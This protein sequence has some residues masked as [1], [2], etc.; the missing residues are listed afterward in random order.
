MRNSPKK[1]TEEEILFLKDNYYKTS[2]GYCA[3]KLK[4][5]I[6]VVY[7]K[8]GRLKLT[9]ECKYNIDIFRSIESK[10]VSYLFG[11]IW[12]DGHVRHDSIIL[13]IL[14]N[15]GEELINIFNEIG[16]YRLHYMKENG[17]NKE[18]T[19][20]A[21]SSVELCNIFNEYDYKLKSKLSPTKILSLIPDNLK[22][23]FYR[24]LIDGDGC[25]YM[26]KKQYTYQFILVSTYEQDWSYM[27]ELCEKLNISKYRIDHNKNKKGKSSS[28]RICRRDDIKILGEYIYKDYDEI[29]LK[30]KYN[31]YKELCQ[32]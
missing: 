27:V 29:G 2:C 23:Y 20:F 16:Y 21:L 26:N 13:A 9:K 32:K 8:I 12:A 6:N 11:I 19:I 28:F 3:E 15:D 24:G 22:C 14:K 18:K 31:K 4:L 1:W 5:P 17:K 7:S 25:F 30:R 10:F